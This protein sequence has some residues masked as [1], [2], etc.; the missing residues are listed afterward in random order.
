MRI[1][2]WLV[3]WIK[4]KFQ[5]RSRRYRTRYVRKAIEVMKQ[6]AHL[7]GKNAKGYNLD[8][9]QSQKVLNNKVRQSVLFYIER[10]IK[11]A[12]ADEREELTALYR[13]IQ[14]NR[15]SKVWKEIKR[16]FWKGY[17]SY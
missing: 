1:W 7:E 8:K 12:T 4:R 15:K 2:N 6:N 17:K 14:I 10:L 3:E 16:F 11:Y 9:N 5:S 13:E